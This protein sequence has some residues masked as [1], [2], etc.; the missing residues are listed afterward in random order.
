MCR[1][2]RVDRKNDEICARQY[3]SS[4][5]LEIEDPRLQ[6]SLKTASFAQILGENAKRELYQIL[7]N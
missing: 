1:S 5:S 2:G 3:L 6:K 4:S 7:N